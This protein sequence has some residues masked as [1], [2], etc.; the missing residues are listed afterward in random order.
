MESNF[1]T[2]HA[3]PGSAEYPHRETHDA[4]DGK[5]PDTRKHLCSLTQPEKLL[6]AGDGIGDGT[7]AKGIEVVRLMPF[8]RH[9]AH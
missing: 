5:A 3:E 9:V 8:M 7:I 1:A 2:M 4:H 6:G